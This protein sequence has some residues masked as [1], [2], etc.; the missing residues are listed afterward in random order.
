MFK[1]NERT[2]ILFGMSCRERYMWSDN[3]SRHS[4]CHRAMKKLSSGSCVGMNE[5]TSTWKRVYWPDSVATG[6]THTHHTHTHT[7]THTVILLELWSS[8]NINTD[9]CFSTVWITGQENI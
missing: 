8:V 7:P 3:I 1:G 2:V 9:I 5:G 6:E 4:G